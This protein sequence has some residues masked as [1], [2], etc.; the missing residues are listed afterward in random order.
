MTVNNI[1]AGVRRAR[2]RT[3]PRRA[4]EQSDTLLELDSFKLERIVSWGNTTPEGEWYDQE[5]DEWVIVLS[6]RATLSFE[7]EAETMHLNPGD[8][9]H[10]AAHRRHRVAWTDPQ[11]ETVWLALHFSPA[12]M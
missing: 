11:C 8:Y 4:G 3:A 9:V 5:R 2:D 7:N 12:P 1:L 6:G 10:L